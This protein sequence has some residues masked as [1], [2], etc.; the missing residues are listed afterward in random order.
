MDLPWKRHFGVE[1]PTCKTACV[2]EL[3]TQ[4]QI[5]AADKDP[6]LALRSLSEE[7]QQEAAKFFEEHKKMGHNP[8]PTLVAIA[9]LPKA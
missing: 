6:V 2:T 4:E 3:V 8:V 5:D 7:D 9:P 1:C